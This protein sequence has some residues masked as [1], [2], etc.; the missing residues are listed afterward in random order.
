MFLGLCIF[1]ATHLIWAAQPTLALSMKASPR[2]Q[3]PNGAVAASWF[4]TWHVGDVPLASVNWT[5]YNMAF[6]AFA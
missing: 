5:E 6:Y 4:A 2:S 3:K 1:V